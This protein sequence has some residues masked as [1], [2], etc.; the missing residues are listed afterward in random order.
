MIKYLMTLVLTLTAGTGLTQAQ[1]VTDSW[2]VGG[3]ISYP[4]LF[5]ANITTLNRN[6]GAY[7]TL[8]RN[9]SEHVGLRVKGGYSNM[10]G[11][12]TD[13]SL[14]DI[15][16]STDMVRADLDLLYYLVPCAPVSP[17]LSAGIGANYKTITNGQTVYPDDN[18]FGSQLNLGLGAEF[19]I[20]P[21]WSL[22][23]EFGY[24]LTNNSELEGTIVPAELNGRDS[25]IVFSAGVN[26]FFN[27][28][29]PSRQCAP[30]GA[31][32][33]DCTDLTNYARIESLI[34]QHI[35]REVVKEVIKEVAVDRYIMALTDDKLLLVGVN[36]AFDKSELLPESYP[37]LDKSV[38]LLN[39]TPGAKFEVEGYTDYVGTA[40]Y[41]QQLSVE[42]AQVV[43]AYLVSKG[44]DQSR[45]TTVGFGKNRPAED[46]MTSEG[47]AMN[48]RI[49]FKIIK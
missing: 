21:R 43:K 34:V 15:T 46:N 8:Q 45:L 12:W 29:E 19:K 6:F 23:T 16:A 1:T 42:R 44:I 10:T 14:Q 33:S 26:F 7:L 13:A 40:A 5:S 47:R 11:Q 3:G 35:P 31:A 39:E 27:Q 18:K 30:C 36:F 17:Y 41:N 9:F 49:M 4:R 20:Q 38:E 24:H 37:V 25:Y 22:I 28:G 32:T 2:A 48:R